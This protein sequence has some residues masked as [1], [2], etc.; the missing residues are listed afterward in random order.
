MKTNRLPVKVYKWE[1][2][3]K[4]KGW[5][6]DLNH[7]L[8]YCNMEDCMGLERLY[9][10]DVAEA[11]LKRNN[12]DKWWLDAHTKPKLRTYVEVHDRS[13]V[14]TIVKRNLS[15][16]HRSLITKLKCGVLPLAIEM[17]RFKD[18]KEE[19]RLCI[20]CTGNH[21]ENETHFLLKCK[22]L[23]ET[24]KPFKNE[25]K[26]HIDWKATPDHDIVK[27]MLSSDMLKL[28][29]DMVETLFNKRNELM[30][31]HT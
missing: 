10:L 25:F 18:V 5:V 9:D 29:C 17:G 19:H 23:K 26:K 13:N 15:R 20:I 7:V 21:V 28:T 11:R 14:Q 4:I 16:S 3:L 2:S 12:R 27:F 24:Q 22:A 1:S 31:R 6:R 30:Y 8:Q